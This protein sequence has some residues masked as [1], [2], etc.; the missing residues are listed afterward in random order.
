MSM[1]VL[2]LFAIQNAPNLEEWKSALAAREIPISIT[3]QV[4]ISTHSGF[5]PMRLEDEESGLHFLIDDYADLAANIP[6]LKDVSLENPV[7]YSLGYGG[8][9]DEA[10][11]ALYSAYALTVEFNGLAFDPQTG[12]FIDPGE[13]LAVAKQIHKMASSR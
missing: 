5:L 1:E 13:L 12:A 9:L 8:R 3:E 4:D 6:L 2:V 11:V 7:V 10:V